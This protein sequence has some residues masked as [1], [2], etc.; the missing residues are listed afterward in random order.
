MGPDAALQ[1]QGQE[2]NLTVTKRGVRWPR[3]L[4]YETRS[5]K[6]SAYPGDTRSTTS[7]VAWSGAGNH[8]PPPSTPSVDADT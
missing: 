7:M 5:F 6:A 2:V 8:I 4:G 3:T 1:L